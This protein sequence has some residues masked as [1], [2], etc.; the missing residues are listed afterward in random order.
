MSTENEPVKNVNISV[1]QLNQI[2]VDPRLL[3]TIAQFFDFEHLKRPEW[4]DRTNIQDSL[5]QYAHRIN[6]FL[7]DT[8][9]PELTYLVKEQDLNP[10]LDVNL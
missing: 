2:L 1:E 5:R 9:I 6:T 10:P 3:F 7:D 8:G 4:G